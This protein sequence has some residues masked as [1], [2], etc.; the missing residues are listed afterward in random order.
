MSRRDRRLA[1]DG[2]RRGDEEAGE[3]GEQE[4]GRRDDEA[5]LHPMDEAA[6]VGDE[7][8]EYGDS[9]RAA[10]LTESVED[11]TVRSIAVSPT[12]MDVTPTTTGTRVPN[13]FERVPL[14]ML[15]TMLNAAEG[16]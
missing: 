13:R 4:K 5:G 16:R 8:A 3:R 11:C 15:P 1:I 12:T 7:R 14:T 2:A 10:H 6:G 9:D